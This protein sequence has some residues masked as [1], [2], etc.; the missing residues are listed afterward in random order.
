MRL[1][2]LH[3]ATE[4]PTPKTR[5]E[6]GEVK[7][8]QRV[9]RLSSDEGRPKTA[10]SESRIT[11]IPEITEAFEKRLSLREKTNSLV[12]GFNGKNKF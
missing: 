10:T 2:R 6:K 5:E 4:A 8:H 9:H 3:A 7:P 12:S 11:T 1:N